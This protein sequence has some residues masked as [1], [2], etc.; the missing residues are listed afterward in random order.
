MVDMMQ[1]ALGD[2]S[3]GAI[4]SH[5]LTVAGSLVPVQWEG[6]MVARVPLASRALPRIHCRLIIHCRPVQP[7]HPGGTMRGG[8][9]ED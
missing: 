3:A 6:G 1:Y 5:D 7:L 2:T 9:Q 8:R 4:G